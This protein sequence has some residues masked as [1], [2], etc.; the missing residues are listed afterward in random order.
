MIVYGRLLSAFTRRVLVWA[1]LQERAFEH[2]PIQV[3][4]DEFEELK[5]IHPGGRVPVVV[6]ENGVRLADSAA[7]VDWLEW[8]APVEKRLLPQDPD[9]RLQALAL[10]GHANAATEKGV[11]FFY[12]KARRPEAFRWT[13]WMDRCAEQVSGSLAV[14]EEACPSEGFF[15][16]AAPGGVDIAATSLMDFLAMTS[17]DVV[18][19]R[20]PKLT[21]LA[22]RAN[23]LP[24]FERWHPK[25]M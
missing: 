12:E 20:C 23:A 13:E 22:A 7:I 10:Y 2:R 4:G 18:A 6:F 1:T 21:A 17:P 16:G 14:L 3:V 25:N 9:A 24:A 11:S 15:A 19:D 8:T 5:K